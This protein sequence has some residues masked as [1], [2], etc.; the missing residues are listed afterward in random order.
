[1]LVFF[2]HM[3]GGG[4]FAKSVPTKK[5]DDIVKRKCLEDDDP[6]QAPAP[7]CHVVT[8]VGTLVTKVKVASYRVALMVLNPFVQNQISGYTTFL[9]YTCMLDGCF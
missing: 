7:G 4:C 9:R 2:L 5:S 3:F 8:R 1:M 6:R